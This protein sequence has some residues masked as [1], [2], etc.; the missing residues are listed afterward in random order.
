LIEIREYEDASGRSRFGEWFDVLNTE[1]A[2]KVNTAITRLGLGHTSN[3]KSVG[4]GV[5]EY[6]IDFGPRYRPDT[7]STSDGTANSW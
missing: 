1:A 7:E 3:V 5:F 2:L 4:S 6:K